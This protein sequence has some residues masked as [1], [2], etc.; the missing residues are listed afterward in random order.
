MVTFGG[1]RWTA[2]ARDWGLA[3]EQRRSLFQRT[4]AVTGPRGGALL[5]AGWG[6]EQYPGLTVTIRFPRALDVQRLR[7]LLAEDVSLDALPGRASARRAIKVVAAV[8]P[9]TRW[10]KPPEYALTETSLVWRRVF[11]W[12]TPSA[13]RIQAWVD[14]LVAAV[15]R[16]T[17]GF[18]GRCEGCGVTQVRQ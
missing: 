2:W 3:H 12:G 10:G 7:D 4:E 15:G 5:R 9:P 13:A 16:A 18:D 1:G 14:A 6:D 11:S 8:R 17:P